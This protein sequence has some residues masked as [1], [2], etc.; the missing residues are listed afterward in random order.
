M[1]TLHTSKNILLLRL[2]CLG[3]FPPRFPTISFDAKT[4]YCVAA[5]AEQIF[6]DFISM[7]PIAEPTVSSKPENLIHDF[8]SRH[9]CWHKWIEKNKP[10]TRA[11]DLHAAIFCFSSFIF[12]F[13]EVQIAMISQ[14][15]TICITQRRFYGRHDNF[16]THSHLLSHNVIFFLE[17][18]SSMYFVTSITQSVDISSENILSS[19]YITLH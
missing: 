16:P 9:L 1:I 12:H 11:Y 6:A 5:R 10:K 3:I 17:A 7:N 8:V 2:C 18:I 13:V 4:K 15:Y 14:I 19:T